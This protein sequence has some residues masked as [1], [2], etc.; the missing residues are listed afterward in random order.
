[1]LDINLI[2]EQPDLVRT[3]LEN[4]QI[5]A[6]EHQGLDRI[7]PEGPV[8]Q[9]PPGGDHQ[10]RAAVARILELRQAGKLLEPAGAPS[11][12]QEQRRPR[13]RPAHRLHHRRTD[14]GCA[15][16]FLTYLSA[17]SAG[18]AVPRIE[19]NIFVA[20][21]RRRAPGEQIAMYFDGRPLSPG[22][23]ETPISPGYE[24]R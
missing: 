4:R 17:A 3:A 5:V 15:P 8:G 20:I 24:F 19:W 9:G 2:R 23:M 18:L 1:M 7:E 16:F 22:E 14:S 11:R 21:N 12:Q 6:G 13:Q 10:P